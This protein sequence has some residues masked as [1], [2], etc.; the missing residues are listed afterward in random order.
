MAMKILQAYE[1]FVDTFRKPGKSAENDD[2]LLEK[3]DQFA[4]LLY[5]V[6]VRITNCTMINFLKGLVPNKECYYQAT[7]E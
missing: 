7:M 3:F 4:C 6:Q 2:Q 5:G 1:S